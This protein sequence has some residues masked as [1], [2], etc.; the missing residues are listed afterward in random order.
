MLFIYGVSLKNEKRYSDAI[1]EFSK[2]Q[3][4]GKKDE[5]YY[6]SFVEKGEIYFILEEYRDAIDNYKLY[7]QNKSYNG[8]KKEV[9][10]QLSNGYYNIK[11]YKL[12]YQNYKNYLTLYGDS[13]DIQNK[14]AYSLLKDDNYKEILAFFG[15]R[16]KTYD[17]QKYLIVLS[18]YKLKEFEKAIQTSNDLLIKSN[19]NY[20][21]DIS[22]INLMS[23]IET[24]TIQI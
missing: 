22:Y 5:I 15:E 21:Y 2:I 13:E 9:L 24:T 18:N 23:R 4:R 16:Q 19:N 11:N 17:F 7:L 6:E 20:Y 1:V 3:K 12:A 8:R 14:I 10:L